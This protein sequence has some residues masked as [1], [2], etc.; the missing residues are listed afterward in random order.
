M[1]VD[2]KILNLIHETKWMLRMNLDVPNAAKTVL[3]REK[4]FKKYKMHLEQCLYDYKLVSRPTYLLSLLLTFLLWE[5]Q[6]I[7]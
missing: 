2:Q 6:Q 3:A 7:G 5:S 1:N 4:Q